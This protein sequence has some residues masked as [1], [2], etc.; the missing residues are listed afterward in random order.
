MDP[1]ENQY[2]NARSDELSIIFGGGSDD[3]WGSNNESHFSSTLV[4]EGQACEL[5][6]K[7]ELI[8]VKW[9]A[10]K[11]GVNKYKQRTRWNETMEN[12]IEML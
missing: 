10:K 6:R 11:K 1:K 12:E 7:E 9:A 8:I 3:G 5:P 4:C 2:H